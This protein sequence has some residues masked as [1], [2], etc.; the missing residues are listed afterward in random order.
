[1]DEKNEFYSLIYHAIIQKNSVSEDYA[2]KLAAMA[3]ISEFTEAWGLKELEAFMKEKGYRYTYPVYPGG[4]FR[5][6]KGAKELVESNAPKAFRRLLWKLHIRIY[7][8]IV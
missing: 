1:M 8:G 7:A 2:E 6:D 5:K 3:G 4:I